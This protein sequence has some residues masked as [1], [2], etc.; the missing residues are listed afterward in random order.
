MENLMAADVAERAGRRRRRGRIAI[1]P[2]A[3][4]TGLTVAACGG[5]GSSSSGSSTASTQ[6]SLTAAQWAN[7]VCGTLSTW[8]SSL[9]TAPPDVSNAASPDEAKTTLTNYM[10][11]LVASTNTMVSGLQAA[12][13]PAVS[14]GQAISQGFVGGF[15]AFQASFVQAQNQANA[16]STADPTAFTAGTQAL[17]ASLRNVSTVA[18]QAKTNLD[19]LG[20]RYS[21]SQ[22]DQAFNNSATC[23]S[24]K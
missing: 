22:L 20:Q 23:K 19:N 15:Q 6:A 1:V 7:Q 3:L 13:S 16:I 2:L 8:E 10:N 11:N 12:G 4:V 24:L 18:N 21:S 9:T 17:A 5:G 14:N